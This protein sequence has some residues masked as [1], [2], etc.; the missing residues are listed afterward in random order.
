MVRRRNDILGFIL[1]VIILL[2]LNFLV[3]RVSL[4]WDL[5]SEKRYSLNEVTENLV[6]EIDDVLLFKVYLEGDLNAGFQKLQ[7]ET[8]QMLN[9]L[10]ARNENIQFE[11]INPVVEDDPKSTGE[12]YQQLRF[13]GLEPIQV[14]KNTAEGKSVRQIFPGAIVSY[15]DREIPVQV[16][17]NQFA[18]APE[19]QINV[20]IQNLEYTLA[21]AIRKLL[22]T[23]RPTV[24]FLKGHGELED[25]KVADIARELS[26]YYKM[27]KFNIKEFNVD[28]LSGEISI[29]NQMMRMNTIDAL[30]I[31]KPTKRFSDLDKLLLDQYIMRGGKTL[32]FID[33]V[34][35]DLDSLSKKPSFLAFPI[36]EEIG[37]TDLLFRY[38]VRVNSNLVQDMVA[39]GVNDTREVN[40]W[41]YFPLMMPQVKHPITKDLNAI[42]LEFASTI[43]TIIAPGV[44]KNITAQYLTLFKNRFHSAPGEHCHPL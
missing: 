43:D 24:A 6:E 5:T 25:R 4:R 39:A 15:K 23:D 27:E 31:A 10:R 29:Q 44:K 13:K 14:E 11:F 42:K 41:V 2:L 7:R 20:S 22:I 3:S 18:S 35:A 34:S 9:E 8:L 26:Q 1:T 37:L 17:L 30:I 12:I 36:S 21:N 33:A 28:T 38:G 19:A 32:W 40:R 16:L